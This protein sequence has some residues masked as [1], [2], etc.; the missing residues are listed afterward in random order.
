[1]S[2]NEYGNWHIWAVSIL[3]HLIVSLNLI[4]WRKMQPYNIIIGLKEF[5]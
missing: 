3:I 1:M 5:Y 4:N 2:L